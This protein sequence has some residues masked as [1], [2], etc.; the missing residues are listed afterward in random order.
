[1]EDNIEKDKIKSKPKDLQPSW[2]NQPKFADLY[3]NYTD[4]QEDQALVIADLDE[5]E[6]NLDG[7]PAVNAPK[8]K[9]SARPKLIRKQL[10]W[11]IPALE[12]PF[13]NTVDM[14]QIK[15][16]TYEDVD[17]AKQNEL[18]INYQWSTKVDKVRLVNNISRTIA[19]DGIVIVKTGWETDEEE[20]MV[21]KEVPVYASPE[22][23]IQI[24]QQA[25]ESGEMS[26]EQA[27]QILE[28][29]QPVQKGTEV[30]QVPEYRLI[31]NQPMYTV[32]DT[33]NLQ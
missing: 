12:E 33:R 25:L 18:L 28:S 14:F 21:D 26:E 29:G 30:V 32:C 2:K 20:I 11:K 10:E 3:S 13:L 1:L 27:Q 17:K 16:R 5:R 19:T 23:S 15:P 4:A 31:K 24:I 6:T 7:G 8:G 22:E 9:S